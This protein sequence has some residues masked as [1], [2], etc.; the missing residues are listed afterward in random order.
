MPGL[1]AADMTCGALALS[2]GEDH[3]LVICP[4]LARPP[5]PRLRRSGQHLQEGRQQAC[6]EGGQHD[7]EAVVAL[8]ESSTIFI[9][10]RVEPSAAGEE[11]MARD[12]ADR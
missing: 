12:T 3:D 4:A 1:C 9:I 6:F 7:A 10:A 2:W 5:R 11:P 8:L